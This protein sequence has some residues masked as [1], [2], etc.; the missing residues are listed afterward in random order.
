MRFN[1]FFLSTVCTNYY[2]Q[3][4][5]LSLSPLSHL[6]R[7]SHSSEPLKAPKRKKAKA[8]QV[9]KQILECHWS[10]VVFLSPCALVQMVQENWVTNT[11]RPSIT[12]TEILHVTF[13]S[14]HLLL[15][16]SML[17][18]HNQKSLES[19]FLSLFAS[20]STHFHPFALSPSLSLTQLVHFF[21][22]IFT[23][24]TFSSIF[25]IF[26]LAQH[27]ICTSTVFLTPF[28]TRK[29]SHANSSLRHLPLAS[30]PLQCSSLPQLVAACL[31]PCLTW[32]RRVQ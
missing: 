2:L 3:C 22:H 4:F 18:F 32:V 11:F 1:I 31:A 5:S 13:H 23:C 27:S 7:P 25:C 9:A 20:C 8:R 30:L 26:L 29:F 10:L 21:S 15:W 6:F 19:F 12:Q 16:H 24:N 28:T 14:I 17:P